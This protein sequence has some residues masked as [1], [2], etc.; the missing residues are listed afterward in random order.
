M[1]HVL[2]EIARPVPVRVLRVAGAVHEHHA[3]TRLVPPCADHFRREDPRVHVH[4][5]PGLVGDDLRID[6][7]ERSPLG[8]RRRRHL[9]RRR[10][11]RVGHQEHFGRLVAVGIHDA[12]HRVVRR[13]LCFVGTGRRRDPRAGAAVDGHRVELPLAR[14]DF[15]ARDV[16]LLRVW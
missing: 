1:E 16:E 2:T 12:E 4:A 9:L 3:W 7:F 6:P 13:Y 14:V 10:A 11:R 15:R 8:R 5:V